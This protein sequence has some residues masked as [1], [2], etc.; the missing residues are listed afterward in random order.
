ME[1]IITLTISVISIILIYYIFDV[2]VKKIKGIGENKELKEITDKFPNNENICKSILKM[3]K[4]EKV[5]IKQNE[6]SKDKTSLY[7]AITDTILIADIKDTFVRVQT[8]AHECLHSV[9]SRKIL[10][11]NFIYTNIYNLYFAFSIIFTILGIYKNYQLQIVILTIMGLIFYVVRSYLETDAMI[12]ARYVAKEYMTEY[13][14]ENEICT[15]EDIEKIVSEYDKLNKVGV[16]TY[17]FILFSKTM[18]KIMI[19]NVISILILVIR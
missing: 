8:I 7:I 6:D 10:V 9:Q 18:I 11:F 14:K 15:A 13:I 4:N 19:Y 12:K 1:L 2:N 5:K 17:N 16:P 3:L